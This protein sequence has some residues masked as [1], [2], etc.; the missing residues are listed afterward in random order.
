MNRI[1]SIE[2]MV[3]MRL[4]F[5]GYSPCW[6]CVCLSVRHRLGRPW[7]SETLG[8]WPIL[9]PRFSI[10]SLFL[11]SRAPMLSLRLLIAEY[12]S[13]VVGPQWLSRFRNVHF[14]Q[15]SP[16][17]REIACIHACFRIREIAQRTRGGERARGPAFRPPFDNLSH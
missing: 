3:N 12:L 13:F 8:G 5:T 9:S 14:S 10:F 6:I 15:F 2:L 7:R 1:E 4:F 11:P 17:R 16:P